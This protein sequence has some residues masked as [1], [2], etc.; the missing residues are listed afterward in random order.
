MEAAHQDV[1]VS[2]RG[3]TKTYGAGE[4]RVMALRGV[5][6][7]VRRGELLMLV[8]PSGCGKTTLI[9]VI[10][11]ILDQSG[12]EVRVLERDLRMLSERERARFRGETIGFVFQA[13]NLIPALTA[14][15]NAA[16]PLLIQGVPRS[17]ALERAREVLDAVGLTARADA[18]PAQLSGGQQQRVAIA[19]ALVHEPRIIVCDE[20]TSALDAET[21]HAV[22]EL[23]QRVA[24]SSERALVVVTHDARI[25]GFADRIAHMDDGRIQRIVDN[26]VSG[27][28]Q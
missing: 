14:A 6:L 9:S 17:R 15:E 1:A 27:G 26:H 11:A 25:F 13:Y 19:R 10:A 28:L 7:D 8:G 5:D 24:Q 23:L 4:A 20:P 22:M 12:G 3:L 16:V 21:G 2:V 18:R